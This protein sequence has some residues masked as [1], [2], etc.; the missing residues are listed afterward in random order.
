MLCPIQDRTCGFGQAP[1]DFSKV[2]QQWKMFQLCQRILAKQ[3]IE[4]PVGS[5][6]P[7]QSWQD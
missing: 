2:V 7:L 4:L 5:S 3:N 1:R 6:Q